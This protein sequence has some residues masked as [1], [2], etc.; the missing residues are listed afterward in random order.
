MRHIQERGSIMPETRQLFKTLWLMLSAALLLLGGIPA[1][2]A[3]DVVKEQ[4]SI[5][6][7]LTQQLKSKMGVVQVDAREEAEKNRN[8]QRAIDL[9]KRMRTEVEEARYLTDADRKDLLRRLD[10]DIATYRNRGR[11]I[12][13]PGNDKD[14]VKAAAKDRQDQIKEDQRKNEELARLY[15]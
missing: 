13:R 12:G 3:D 6:I 14:N 11:L 2:R 15:R 9:L 5:D 4:R 10:A 1:A 7:I 8:P